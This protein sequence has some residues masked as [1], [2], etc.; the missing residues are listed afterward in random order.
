VIQNIATTKRR[1]NMPQDKN[2]RSILGGDDLCHA[3][4]T[5]LSTQ[6]RLDWFDLEIFKD[7][8]KWSPR[9]H[10]RHRE[11][12][13]KLFGTDDFF[14]NLC[15]PLERSVKQAKRRKPGG[16]ARGGKART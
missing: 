4:S 11:L 15:L 9:D 7:Q 5:K 1:T 3:L 2:T 6:E 14:W 16:A 10:R 8:A 12:R 13:V